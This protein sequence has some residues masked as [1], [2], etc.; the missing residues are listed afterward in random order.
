[1][2]ASCNIEQHLS[3]D[4]YNIFM[5]M[6]NRYLKYGPSQTSHTHLEYGKF[7]AF[8]LLRGGSFLSPDTRSESFPENCQKFHTP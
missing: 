2:K 3:T 5:K 8:L 7:A 4:I 6:N 1:M